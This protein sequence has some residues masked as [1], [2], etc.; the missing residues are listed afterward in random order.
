MRAI[1]WVMVMAVV[2]GCAASAGGRGA[3]GALAAEGAGRAALAEW[4]AQLENAQAA[5]PQAWLTAAERAADALQSCA[6]QVGCDHVELLRRWVEL[7]RQ[8]NQRLAD[9]LQGEVATAPLASQDEGATLPSDSTQGALGSLP[10]LAETI[11]LINGQELAEV[12]VLNRPVK[13]AI[14]EWLTWMRPQLLEA[15]DN[16]RYLRAR[17]WPSYERAGLPEA[18]LFGILAKESAGKVHAVSSAG[19]AG[20][21][22]FMPATGQRFGLGRSSDGFD[23]RFDPQLSAE[24]NVAYLN[25]RFV[26]FNHDLALAL[27]AYNGGEGRLGRL[28]RQFGG[29]GFWDTALQARLPKETRDYV[30]MVLAAAWLFLH[31]DAVGLQFEPPA[32]EPVPLRLQRESS[33]NALA[34][35]L[36]QDGSRSGWFRALRNLNPRWAPHDPLP[37]GTELAVP[38]ELLAGYQRRCVDGEQVE[39]AEQVA[40]AAH[41]HL[42]SA[43]VTTVYTVRR[44]DTLATIARRHHCSPQSLAA[45]NGIRAPRYLIKPGQELRLSAC[46]S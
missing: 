28:H 27:A 42:G 34:I 1:G 13:A 38:P 37:I 41:R 18:L 36:G 7:H 17:M 21:L 9:T 2:G 26:Q 16:Y 32:A 39:L 29:R 22:Q 31:P 8:H 6:G 25:E 24:A 10:A 45:A 23:T 4:A 40:A 15:H 11:T 19:A 43:A 20:P 33:L 30:P 14:N 12:I 44:G 5:D 3:A 46:R 35:C